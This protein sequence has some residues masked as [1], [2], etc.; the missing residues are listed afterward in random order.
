MRIQAKNQDGA[1]ACALIVLKPDADNLDAVTT[2][3]AQA[4]VVSVNGNIADLA[5]DTKIGVDLANARLR[6]VWYDRGDTFDTSGRTANGVDH[7]SP[8]DHKAVPTGLDAPLPG[9]ADEW[10]I[11]TDR[12]LTRNA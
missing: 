1:W 6:G 9:S 10:T 11:N 5:T 3:A 12:V 4:D 2:P 8:V 7:C